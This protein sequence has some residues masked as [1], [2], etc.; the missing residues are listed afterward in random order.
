MRTADMSA[1]GD[2]RVHVRLICRS[3]YFFLRNLG[4]LLGMAENCAK[5]ATHIPSGRPVWRKHARSLF[6][7]H[8]LGPYRSFCPCPDLRVHRTKVKQ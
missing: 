1:R 6:S 7:L 8:R 2:A 3:R 5:A 4:L